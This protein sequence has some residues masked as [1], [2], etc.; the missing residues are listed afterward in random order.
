MVNRMTSQI[1]NQIPNR[2]CTAPH[3]PP[4]LPR[5]L[6]L[7]NQCPCAP[8]HQPNHRSEGEDP[9]AASV[10]S[11]ELPNTHACAPDRYS[12]KWSYVETAHVVRRPSSSF[13]EYPF[14]TPRNCRQDIAPKRIHA[15]LLHTSLARPSSSSVMK[16]PPL[17]GM[18][19]PVNRPFLKTMST[20]STSMG[21]R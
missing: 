18:T 9:Y 14:L 15:W 10:F 11:R 4:T 13:C 2:R 19:L 5:P 8:R 17:I 21:K 1:R 16:A 3:F 20:T 7:T 6:P 12:A